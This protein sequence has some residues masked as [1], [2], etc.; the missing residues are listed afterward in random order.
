[1]TMRIKERILFALLLAAMLM[2]TIVP[3]PLPR[4]GLLRCR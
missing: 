3:L 2:L 4:K 1:M